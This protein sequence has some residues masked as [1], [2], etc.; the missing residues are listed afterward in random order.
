MAGGW[1]G[2]TIVEYSSAVPGGQDLVKYDPVAR[3]TSV[4]FCF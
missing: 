2:I 4:L 3:K 1:I